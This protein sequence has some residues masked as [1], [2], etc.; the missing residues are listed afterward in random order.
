[1]NIISSPTATKAQ[2]LAWVK[3]KSPNQLAITLLDL[4]WN[5]AVQCGVDPVVV[6]TQSMIETAYMR[7]GGV[8]DASYCNPCGLK[9]TQ[10]GSNTDPNAHE[11]FPTWAHGILAQCEHL[12]LYGGKSGYPLGNPVDPRHFS[13]LLGT[14]PTVEGL[15]NNW[16]GA[17]YGQDIVRLCTEVAKTVA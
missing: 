3:T 15:S 8:L 14:S 7:F 10:G 12:A 13:Y 5:V 1:M 9:I 17:T 4:Y 2:L 6:Y 16:A 11:K